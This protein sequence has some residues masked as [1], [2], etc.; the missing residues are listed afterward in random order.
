MLPVSIEHFHA[1]ALGEGNQLFGRLDAIRRRNNQGQLRCCLP[2]F[3][4]R[5]DL[6]VHQDLPRHTCIPN[7]ARHFRPI[8]VFE[9]E[10]H[11]HPA[12]DSGKSFLERRD[13]ILR[14]FGSFQIPDLQGAN[15]GQRHLA[16]LAVAIGHAI[17]SGIMHQNVMPIRGA[18][19]IDLDV[20]DPRIGGITKRLKR[21]LL[22]TRVVAPVGDHDESMPGHGKLRG[23]ER[24]CQY[25]NEHPGNG[26]HGLIV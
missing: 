23:V 17:H 22:R 2:P 4:Y 11:I 14:H 15:L 1:H 19:D 13:T 18:A 26:F 25:Q 7:H 24:K 10:I 5:F 20:I 12:F 3:R 16:D 9:I 8:A 21:V 6:I